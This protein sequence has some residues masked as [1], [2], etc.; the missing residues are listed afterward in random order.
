[1]AAV[2]GVDEDALATAIAA[3]TEAAFGTW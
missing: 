3:S 2:K 1:M